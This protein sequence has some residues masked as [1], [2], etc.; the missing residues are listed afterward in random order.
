[1]DKKIQVG[2]IILVILALIAGYFA[3]TPQ[4]KEIEMSGYAFEVPGSNAE[5]KNNTI[6]YNTYLDSEN[7][8]N[9]K[10]WA[11]KDI[12]DINGT[13][14][15]SMEMATQLRENMGNNVTYNNITLYNKSGIYTYYEADVNNSCMIIITSKNLNEIEH[16]LET[17]KKPQINIVDSSQFNMTTSGLIINDSNNNTTSNNQTTT[18]SSSSTKKTSS[19]SKSSSSSNNGYRWSEQYGDYIKEYTDSNGVQHIDSKKGY[20]SSYNPKTGEFKEKNYDKLS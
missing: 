12:N 2:I 5:V 10:T 6:N 14:T 4:Y 9:I 8:L 19:S 3:L 16:I 15:C 17:M 7:D 20:R 1:M 13:V 18:T 11:C